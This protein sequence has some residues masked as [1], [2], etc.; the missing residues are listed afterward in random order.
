MEDKIPNRVII[1]KI[2]LQNSVLDGIK[3]KQN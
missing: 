3:T 1:E 2:G